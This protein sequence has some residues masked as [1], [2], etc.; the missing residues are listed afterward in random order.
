M[1][2]AIKDMSWS[3]AGVTQIVGRANRLGQ[4][5]TVHVYTLSALGSTDVLMAFL[6]REKDDMLEALMTKDRNLGEHSL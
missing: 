4:T 3:S 5:K 1:N 6:A 2:S